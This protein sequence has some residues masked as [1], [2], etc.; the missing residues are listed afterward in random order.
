MFF[1]KLTYENYFQLQVENYHSQ[2]L[3]IYTG[4]QIHI[5]RN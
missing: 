2:L 1:R 4:N 3:Y 5:W